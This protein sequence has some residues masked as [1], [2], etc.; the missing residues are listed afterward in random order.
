VIQDVDTGEVTRYNDQGDYLRLHAGIRRLEL[1]KELI[2]HNIIGH[3]IPVLEKCYPWFNPLGKII[4]TL[5]LSRVIFTDMLGR[6]MLSNN[7]DLPKEMKGRHSLEAWGYRLREHKGGSPESWDHWSQYMEDYCVQDVAVNLKLYKLQLS[8]NYSQQC[9]DLE[10]DFASII[11]KQKTHGWNFDVAGAEKLYVELLAKKTE[12]EQNLQ[13]IF[14][15]VKETMKTPQY[16]EIE[17]NDHFHKYYYQAPTKGELV[18]LIIS[19]GL[20]YSR[21]KDQVKKGPMKVK[22][23]PFNPGSTKQIAQRLIE[24]YGWKPTEFTEETKEPKISEE[25]LDALDYPEIPALQ[26]YL[27]VKKRISQLAEGETAWLKMVTPEGRIHGSINTNGAVTGRCT[28]SGPNT[29]NVPAAYSPYGPEC[30]GLWLPSLGMKAVGWDGSGLELRCLGHYMTP[31]DGG[32]Y[33]RE[34]L[35]GDIH[36]VNQKAAGLETRD[37]AK[38]F[39]YAFLYGAGDEKIGSIVGGGRKEGRRLKKKF[40]ERT[41]A[42]KKLKEAVEKASEKGYLIGLDGRHIKIR[43]KHSALNALLQG[44]GAVIMK[45]ACVNHYNACIA[46]GMTWGVDFA[47]VGNIHD[48]IQAEA[49]PEIDDRVGQLGVEAIQLVTEQY[50]FRCPLD[51]EYKVGN[52]WAETH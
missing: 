47:F 14:P 42:L 21:V 17:G 43:S 13:E 6:D 1:A 31:Y 40:L 19:K 20:K 27:M 32:A 33:T 18:K 38:T 46:E 39:I 22:L 26:L 52:N 15:P 5:V 4:D 34:I 35:E 11:H 16:W 24:K 49:K 3:D 48:E 37:Q 50:N 25:I 7:Q 2:G 9:L 28:H 44:C 8:K 36:T 23:I 10:N 29:G 45:Q 12:A 51:G 30:R 41:P